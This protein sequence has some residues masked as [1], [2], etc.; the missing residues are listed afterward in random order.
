MKK[1]IFM[2]G[3]LITSTSLTLIAQE[4]LTIGKTQ[5]NLGVGLSSWG[6]PIYVGL[7]YGFKKDITLG[8]EFSFR[9]YRENWKNYY[10]SHQIMGVSANGNYHFNSLLNIPQPWDVYAGL[11]LGFYIWSSTSSYPGNHASG[12]GLGAQLGAR[13]Y[14]SSKLGL[15]LEFGGGNAFSGGKFGITY[16]F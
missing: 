16:K 7:D 11:N 13:Y 9:S 1:Y 12:L 10:Y 5:L 4:S 2:L 15:N 6:V 3:L 14:L 8:G